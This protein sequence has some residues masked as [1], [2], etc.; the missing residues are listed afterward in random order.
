MRSTWV[1]HFINIWWPILNFWQYFQI[2]A[3]VYQARSLIGSDDS[4]LSDPF[5]RVVIGEY[6]KTT[7]VSIKYSET[8]IY[9][10]SSSVWRHSRVFAQTRSRL[11]RNTWYSTL[12]NIFSST[13]YLYP[14]QKFLSIRKTEHLSW[15]LRLILSKVPL[16]NPYLG[17]GSILLR[18]LVL[19][20]HLLPILI[21]MIYRYT[22]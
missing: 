12:N 8:V 2:R 14:Q 10:A 4:G 5:A 11:I 18:V 17:L 16:L 7:Q 1:S 19:A 21:L 9:L 13:S 15:F 6:C 3:Y 22:S 20:G